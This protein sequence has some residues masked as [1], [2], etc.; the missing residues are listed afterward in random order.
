MDKIIFSGNLGA[1]PKEQSTNDGKTLVK[2][3]VAVTKKIK[4][5]KVTEWRNVT[6][7]GNTGKFCMDY[8]KKG[9][10]VIVEGK[11]SPRA[12]K[13]KLEETVGVLDVWADNIEPIGA[14]RDG[15]EQSEQTTQNPTGFVQVENEEMPF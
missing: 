15:N 4:G 10:S 3:S 2:L 8:L 14:A 7:S 11:P 9:R 6:C 13:N 1:D 12:Y 5:E